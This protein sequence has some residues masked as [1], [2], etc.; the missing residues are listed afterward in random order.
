MVEA[1]EL[2]V[3][4]DG[5]F[6]PEGGIGGEVGI[7]HLFFDGAAVAALVPSLVP[8]GRGEDGSDGEGEGDDAGY[9]LF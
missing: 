7:L 4:E 6:L 5:V 8:G 3:Q 1:V 9:D 2:S